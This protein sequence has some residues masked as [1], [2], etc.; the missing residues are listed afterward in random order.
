MWVKPFK[1]SK[2]A[3][4]PNSLGGMTLLQSAPR[5]QEKERW[6]NLK[7]KKHRGPIKRSGDARERVLSAGGTKTGMKEFMNFIVRVVNCSLP[8]SEDR[9]M[10]TDPS[11]H[12]A[13]KTTRKL[14]K[15]REKKEK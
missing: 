13:K 5:Q 7:N 12:K 1:V 2:R 9:S 11:T 14:V 6:V 15:K 8:E 3:L 10:K 4:D